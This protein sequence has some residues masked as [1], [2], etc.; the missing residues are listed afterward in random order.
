ASAQTVKV[1]PISEA[2]RNRPDY[3]AAHYGESITVKGVVTDG[4]HDVGSG[5]SLANLQDASGGIAIFGEHAV[6]PPGAFQRGDVLEARGKLAQYRG[7][8]ELQVEEVRRT[9]TAEPPAPRDVLAAQLLGEDYS[10]R[11]VRV[12]GQLI[13]GPKGSVTLR[14]RSGEIP[15]YLFHSF[16]QNT[17]FM[18]RLLQGGPV[19]I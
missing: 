18:Q 11:L 19:E 9:G 17:S 13:L 12:A 15:V 1:M 14:D 5:N 6:L 4:S 7:M 8:E 3:S 2:I 16:F 10:G